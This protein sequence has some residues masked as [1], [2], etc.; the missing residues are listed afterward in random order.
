MISRTLLAPFATFDRAILQSIEEKLRPGTGTA[1]GQPPSAPETP[2]L[3]GPTTASV[4]ASKLAPEPPVVPSTPRPRHPAGCRKSANRKHFQ[5]L[6]LRPTSAFGFREDRQAS[7]RFNGHERAKG[8]GRVSRS[9]HARDGANG[10]RSVGTAV[11]HFPTAL[12]AAKS[13][14][15][16]K[17]TRRAWA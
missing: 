13:G 15:G 14:R 16:R 2:A 1:D 3:G 17:A 10:A 7:S 8:T 11:A 12:L 6:G 9:A 4:G 5:R